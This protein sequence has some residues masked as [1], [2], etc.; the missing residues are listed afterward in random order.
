MRLAKWLERNGLSE[1]EASRRLGIAQSAI[2]RITNEELPPSL[3]TAAKIVRAT[4]RE[5]S[6]EDLLNATI[7]RSLWRFNGRLAA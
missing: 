2:N 1:S 4:N 7:R 5:V 6:Y 3:R